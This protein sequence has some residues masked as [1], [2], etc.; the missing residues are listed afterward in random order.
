M[1]IAKLADGIDPLTDDALPDDT[2]LNNVRLARCFF[3][4][5]GVLEKVIANGGEIGGSR[6]TAQDFSITADELAQIRP[7]QDAVGIT[8][9]CALI[10]AVRPDRKKLGYGVVTEWLAGQGFLRSE[11]VRD[12][13][14]RRV[15]SAGEQI[16]IFEQT[17][18]GLNGEYLTILY[19][20]AAQ[21]FVIDHLPVMLAEKGLGDEAQNADE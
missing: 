14:R 1:Y 15:T 8:Q 12:K 19:N 18:Q 2:L 17:R 6:R 13:K 16:G 5:S 20:T 9:L 21:Q 11:I 10:S 7:A 4:V 3:Y